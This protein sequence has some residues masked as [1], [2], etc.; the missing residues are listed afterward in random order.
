MTIHCHI[1]YGS[2]QLTDISEAHVA[3]LANHYVIEKRNSH[4]LANGDEQLRDL[5]VIQTRPRIYR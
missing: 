1:V 4:L 5:H 2:S 3:I